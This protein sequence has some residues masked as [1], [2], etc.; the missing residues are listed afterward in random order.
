[1]S[2]NWAIVIGINNYDNLELLKY[3]K[4]DAEAMM[5]WFRNEA[6]F[7]Q[8]F[9]FT[10][11]SPAI[12]TNPPKLTQPTHGRF[13]RFLNVQFARPLLEPGDNLWLFFAGHGQQYADQDYLMFID[14]DPQAVDKTAI[15]IEYV[16]QRLRRSGADNVVLF[17]DACRDKGKRSGLGVGGVTAI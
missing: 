15:S 13:I 10:E 14:S 1:M 2:K 11:D 16:T 5:A 12:K 4:R 3:A 6:N 17:I 9:L 7:D 8:V